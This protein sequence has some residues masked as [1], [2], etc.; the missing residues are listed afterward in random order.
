MSDW[1]TPKVFMDGV[2]NLYVGYPIMR[3]DE[4]NKR[5]LWRFENNSTP[6]Y[7]LVVLGSTPVMSG[8][9]EPKIWSDEFSERGIISLGEYRY[10]SRLLKK[11][12][13][14]LKRC[15]RV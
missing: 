4:T 6:K 14:K 2:G 13:S 3:L 9:H 7:E 8:S 15:W 12:S 10:G 5:V 1:P 11:L